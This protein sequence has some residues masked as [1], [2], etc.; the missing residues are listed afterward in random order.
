[1]TTAESSGAA[2][3]GRFNTVITTTTTTSSSARLTLRTGT[4]GTTQATV[5]ST[6][7]QVSV[8]VSIERF[9][10]LPVD[11]AA[12]AAYCPIDASKC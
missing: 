7:A 2:P 10:S 1:M 3:S 12:A 9:P 8:F 4:Q 5:L 11:V 6:C